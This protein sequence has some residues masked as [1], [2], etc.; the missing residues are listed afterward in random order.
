M[1]GK[2]HSTPCFFGKSIS[3]LAQNRRLRLNSCV[4]VMDSQHFPIHLPTSH[5]WFICDLME[6]H[7][8]LRILDGVWIQVGFEDR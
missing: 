1:P 4:G 6:I 8:H 3:N 7:I 5:I 2:K